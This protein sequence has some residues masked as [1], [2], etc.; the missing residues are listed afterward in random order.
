MA[1]MKFFLN[2]TSSLEEKTLSVILQKHHLAEVYD[3]A[4]TGFI[5]DAEL[6]AIVKHQASTAEHNF[7]L[8]GCP[9]GRLDPGVIPENS[10]FVKPMS[11]YGVPVIAQVLGMFPEYRTSKY[12]DWV[13]AFAADYI[14][15]L[16]EMGAPDYKIREILYRDRMARSPRPEFIYEQEQKAS[17]IMTN[18][19]LINLASG[20]K[21]PGHEYFQVSTICS[22]FTEWAIVDYICLGYTGK[23]TIA[24]IWSSVEKDI[25]VSACIFTSHGDHVINKIPAKLPGNYHMTTDFD[26]RTKMKVVQISRSFTDGRTLKSREI[27]PLFGYINYGD[28]F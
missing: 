11:V 22:R 13:G 6:N 2:S 19:Q 25:V 23:C 5:K 1:K 28:L 7:F 3:F 15:G 12:E 8:P 4:R 21:D 24:F 20:V 27:L 14:D 16:R 17:K 9:I 18:G 10:T 26:D